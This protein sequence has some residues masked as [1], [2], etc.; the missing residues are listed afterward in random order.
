[1]IRFGIIQILINVTEI[2]INKTKLLTKL[3][4]K[5]NKCFKEAYN[6]LKTFQSK[7]V[8]HVKIKVTKECVGLQIFKMFFG[9]TLEAF[10]TL[11]RKRV[12]F[13]WYTN[14]RTFGM[15]NFKNRNKKKMIKKQKH[16]CKHQYLRRVQTQSFYLIFIIC[17]T[18]LKNYKKVDENFFMLISQRFYFTLF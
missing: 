9:N 2:L 16:I 5:M 18:I 15:L 3:F 6:H 7:F 13:C 10:L 14:F 17:I 12:P 4:L 11:I 1:M 8:L